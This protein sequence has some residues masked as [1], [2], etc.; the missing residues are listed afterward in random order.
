MDQPASFEKSLEADMQQLAA[1][2]RTQRE[3]PEMQNAQEQDIVKEAIRSFPEVKNYASAPLPAA[4]TQTDS[5]SPLPAYAQSAPPEVKL[6][7]EY[8]LDIAL[9]KGIGIA[10]AESQNRPPSCRTRSM[11]LSPGGCIRNCRNGGW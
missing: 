3:R 8:L 10:I 4:Q 5:N 7:I 6:E 11:M 1:E 9:K 2:I